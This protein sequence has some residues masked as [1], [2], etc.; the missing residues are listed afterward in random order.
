MRKDGSD[1]SSVVVHLDNGLTLVTSSEA[2]DAKSLQSGRVF[3]GTYEKCLANETEYLT[4]DGE[5]KE[6]ERDSLRIKSFATQAA[7]PF[8][9][10]SQID[11]LSN[12]APDA[13]VAIINRL[14]EKAQ[15][16][17]GEEG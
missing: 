15:P 5:V 10:L 2:N 6:H 1:K 9:K 7:T 4:A 11:M 17:L 14:F 8:D 16:A 3:V 13:Q 12:L